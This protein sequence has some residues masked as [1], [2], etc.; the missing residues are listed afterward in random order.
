MPIQ[1]G[2]DNDEHTVY[3]C[4]VTGKWSLEEFLESNLKFHEDLAQ[5]ADPVITIVDLRG[6][7]LLSGTLIEAIDIM[8]VT[9]VANSDFV[10]AI[11]RSRVWRRT[12]QAIQQVFRGLSPAFRIRV[13][14]VTSDREAYQVIAQYR[15]SK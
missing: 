3:H 5:V 13:Q 14:W 9:P 1:V 2:W 11:S 7:Q 4:A 6:A 8:R 12:F 10:V 15:A